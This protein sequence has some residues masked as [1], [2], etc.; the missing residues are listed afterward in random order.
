MIRGLGS[1]VVSIQ[2]VGE[3]AS[4]QGK[5]VVLRLLSPVERSVYQSYPTARAIEFLAGRFAAK[6]AIAKAVGCGLAKI[7]PNRVEVSLGLNGLQ[8]KFLDDFPPRVGA[9]D[10]VW[11]TISHTNELAFAV[12]IWEV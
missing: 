8:A 10:K 7:H 11:I 4:R 12:A 9:Q 6:E 3:L 1:D 2:R 5:K